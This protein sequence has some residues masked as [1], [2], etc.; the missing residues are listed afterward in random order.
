MLPPPNTLC[1]PEQLSFLARSGRREGVLD[2][3]WE[4]PS[5]TSGVV[6]D[7]FWCLQ[8]SPEFMSFSRW[9]HETSSE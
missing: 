7:T 5:P 6:N 4:P 9:F 2:P 8:Q 1:F 3:I